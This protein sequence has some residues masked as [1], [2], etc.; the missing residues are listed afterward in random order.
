MLCPR[1]HAQ[2][3]SSL[4]SRL[5]LRRLGCLSAPLIS[6]YISCSLAL[7]PPSAIP[8]R[9]TLPGCAAPQVGRW[10]SLRSKDTEQVKEY[11]S[12]ADVL[13]GTKTQEPLPSALQN[14]Q[15]AGVIY[16]TDSAPEGLL[17]SLKA[18]PNASSLGL[19]ASSTPFITG[20]PVTLFHNDVIYDSGAVGVALMAPMNSVTTSFKGAVPISIPMTITQREGNMINALDGDSPAKLLLAAIQQSGMD[21][22][23]GGSFKD[24]EKFLLGTGTRMYRITAGDPSRGN[25]SLEPQNV[26]PPEGTSVQFFHVPKLKSAH[27]LEAHTKN[28]LEFSAC[29]ESLPDIVDEPESDGDLPLRTE[30]SFI[31]G[32]ENGFVLR[33]GQENDA[34]TCTV[35][36]GSVLIEW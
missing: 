13:T 11:S 17:S 31:A 3:R 16:F 32:S 15:P 26:A 12:W 5:M 36:G 34:W 25:L 9:S 21:M 18:F 7:F 4:R 23:A 20:R 19:I 33:R 6:S 2:R 29:S 28:G 35:A 1:Q 24:D 27:K 10:H 22:D 30:T 8:F 14:I